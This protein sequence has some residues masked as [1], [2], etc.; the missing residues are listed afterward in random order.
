MTTNAPLRLTARGERLVR[1]A[2]RAA[3][4][5]VSLAL[6][7]GVLLASTADFVAAGGTR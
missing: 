7:G 4:T 5:L 1:I 6:I 3:W 2:R